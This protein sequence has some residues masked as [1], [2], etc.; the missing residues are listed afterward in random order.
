MNTGD[1]LLLRLGLA[2]AIGLVIGIERGWRRRDEPEGSR[3]AGVRTF[4]LIGLLGG[5][6]GALSNLADAYVPWLAGL[7]LV[8]A[9]FG[10]FSYRETRADGD[11][12]VTNLVT[13]MTV[14]VLGVLA[15]LGDLRTAAAAGVV[16]AGLLAGREQLHRA[17]ARLTWTELRAGLLLLAMTV[18]V[19]PLLP[20]RTVD[21][22]DSV[23]PYEL[24]LLTILIAAVSYCGYVA[25]KVAGPDRG[26][27][28][29]G[30]L[31][32]LAS[33][34]A[35]TLAL[36]RQSRQ[37][38][39][40]RSLGSGAAL[41][42][43]VSLVRASLLAV[44]LHPPL[45]PLL[46]PPAAA[47]AL[48]FAGAGVLPL[49]RPAP[50]PRAKVEI[51]IPFELGTVLAFGLLLT[52]VTFVGA[53]VAREAG[54]AG[55][56]LFA[57]ISGLADVD[58]ITLSTARQAGQALSLAVAA[59]AILAAFA[60][61]AVQR[62]VFAAGFGARPFARRYALVTALALAAGAATWG[63]RAAL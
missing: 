7:A 25:L 51:G 52:A 47:A 4:A 37:V 43:T 46:A 24:W 11:F 20:N 1:D 29:A 53:W 45:L 40:P 39:D 58:A 2:L 57:I 16:T 34:T 8:T 18:V 12:S 6:M 15:V 44:A 61:N 60:A 21:V 55:G 42:A 26:P 32:G 35:A 49:L 23:N 28:L 36:A 59:N 48:V 41:A 14:F 10:V 17:V 56:Y 3:T 54:A 33:S 30:L 13:A 22:L 27:P 31:G 19:L 62:A 50:G 63:L 5:L 38:E 9:S